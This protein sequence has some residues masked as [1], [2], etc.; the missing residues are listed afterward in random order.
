[1]QSPTVASRSEWVAARTRL[2]ARE[3]E[4]T[5][6]RD[7]LSAVLVGRIDSPGTFGSCVA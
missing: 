3:K 7:A 4:L 1:M 6:K 2:L 5:R